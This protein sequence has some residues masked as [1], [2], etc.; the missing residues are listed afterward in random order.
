[1]K[2]KVRNTVILV[3]LSLSVALILWVTVFSRIGNE[4]R[5]FYPPFSSYRAIANGSGRALQEVIGNIL[6]FVPVG[7]I[8]G[9]LFH[10][11]PWQAGAV[12]FLFSLVIESCQWFFW[13]GAF[14]IDDLLHNTMGAVCGCLIA[15]L[16]PQIQ[17]RKK[18]AIILISLIVVTASI[19]AGYQWL[20]TEIMERYAAMNDRED[21]TK[22]LL[23]LSPD[24]RYLG[25]TDFTV[26]YNSDG[27]VLIEGYSENRAWIELGRVRLQKGRYMFEGLSDVA[28]DTIAIVLDH[29]DEEERRDRRITEEVGSISNSEFIIDKTDVVRL[30][31]SIY[32]GVRGT[33]VARPV[34]YRIE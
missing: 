18:N 3:A 7:V 29:Y 14:E 28:E 5:R 1:M 2:D 26:S 24:P 13:L 4:S 12:G 21:G 11:N 15:Q 10:L 30:L 19:G 22:N 8:A 33:F 6:L 17:G 32:P 34:I 23:I 20:R 25:E 16:I 31:I 9:L 27:S